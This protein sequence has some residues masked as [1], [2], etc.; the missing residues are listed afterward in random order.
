MNSLKNTVLQDLP[1]QIEEL[2]L[3]F[4]RTR[5]IDSAF[6]KYVKIICQHKGLKVL[7]LTTSG[8]ACTKVHLETFMKIVRKFVSR[9][10]SNIQAS[11]EID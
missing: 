5:L 9:E 2:S 7:E 11:E 6:K 4:I 1:E 8:S 10:D 3:G